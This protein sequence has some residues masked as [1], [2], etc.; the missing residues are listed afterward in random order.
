MK[1]ILLGIHTWYHYDKTEN[2]KPRVLTD[3]QQTGM[4]K[5]KKQ[6]ISCYA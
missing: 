4:T 2:V 5:W 1:L 6:G 3:L